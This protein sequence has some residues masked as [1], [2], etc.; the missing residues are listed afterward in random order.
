MWQS[1]L[2]WAIAILSLGETVVYFANR[3]VRELIAMRRSEQAETA[4]ERRIAFMERESAAALATATADERAEHEK[5]LLLR[6][7]AEA[8]AAAQVAEAPST[9]AALVAE[10]ERVIAARTEGRAQAAKDRALSAS[11]G[12]STLERLV[13]AYKT[14]RNTG[15]GWSFEQ[16]LGDLDTSQF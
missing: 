3:R 7:A 15:G 13:D 1:A 8:R 14:Y 6:E 2:I 10:E 16:W 5:A 9:I 11:E 12:S 4:E